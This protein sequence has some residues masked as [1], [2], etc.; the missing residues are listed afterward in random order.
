MDTICEINADFFVPIDETCIPTG[1]IKKVEGTAFDFRTPLVVGERIDDSNCEQIKNGAGY[2]HCYVLNKK[3]VGELSFAAKIKEPVSGR[4]M[5]VYTTEPGLQFY[6]DNWANGFPG[7]KGA[8]FGRRS[9]LC[10]EA[11]HFPDSPNKP[12]FPSVV[13]NPGEVYTQKTVYKFGV[14][15]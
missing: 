12:H 3:E 14:E 9:A 2:D 7:Y 4:T 6:S 8:P 13:L 1:E 15:S 11:Q 10:F 5:E